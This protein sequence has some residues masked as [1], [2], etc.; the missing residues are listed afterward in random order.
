MSIDFSCQLAQ[1]P[2]AAILI[3][4]VPVMKKLL[5][6]LSVFFLGLFIADYFFGIDVPKLASG[7]GTMLVEMFTATRP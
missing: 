3:A 1:S 4:E 6:P 2:A 7:F 5:L